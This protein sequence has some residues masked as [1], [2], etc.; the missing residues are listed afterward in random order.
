[1]GSINPMSRVDRCVRLKPHHS[2]EHPHFKWA[3]SGPTE[4]GSRRWRRLFVSRNEAEDFLRDTQAGVAVDTPSKNQSRVASPSVTNDGD[5]ETRLT[6]V[7]KVFLACATAAVFASSWLLG[8]RYP[9]AQWTMLV[10]CALSFLTGTLVF[11]LGGGSG[12]RS[13]DRWGGWWV[14]G[15]AAVGFAS[16]VGIQAFNLSHTH[17]IGDNNCVLTPIP[18]QPLLPSSV[19]GPFAGFAHGFIE[20]ENASRYFL[21]YG[22]AILGGLALMIGVQSR[23]C[24]QILL[25]VLLVHGILSALI[26]VAHQWSASTKVLWIQGDSLMF[27]GA[28]FFFNKNQNA[29]YQTLLAGVMLFFA[30]RC[31]VSEGGW[32]RLS[33]VVLFAVAEL[34]LASIRSRA[35]LLFAGVLGVAWLIQQRKTIS[36]WWRSSRL[37]MAVVLSMLIATGSVAL[38]KTGGFSTVQRF[39]DETVSASVVL[40]GGKYRQLLHEIAL[41]MFKDRPWYGWGA[42]GYFYTYAQHE[43]KV[44]AMAA[45][46]PGF[47]YYLLVGHAD[48]DWYEFLAEFGIVGTTIFAVIWLPHLVLWKRRRLWKNPLLFAPAVAVLAILYHGLIDQSFR[49][50]GLLFLHLAT[51]VLVTKLTLLHQSE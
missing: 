17:E 12:A 1:M 47:S 35:G 45:N 4:D 9:W 25:V 11:L 34:G 30:G 50:V 28:P 13:F 8:E 22:A 46:R 24:L 32:T 26:C 19:S 37:G 38:W 21:I 51:A 49:N 43:K 36:G 29:A 14:S 3:V 39:G 6:L 33:G 48:G 27:L 5:Q 20:M 41:E 10:L 15:L 16:F 44:P 18:H 31:V 7:E 42:A 40:H 23:K 2:S